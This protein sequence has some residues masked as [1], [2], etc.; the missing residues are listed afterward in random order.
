MTDPQW[1]RVAELAEFGRRGKKL[2]TVGSE[3]IALFA[4]GGE[5]FAFQ[6]ACVHKDRPLSRGTLLNGRVVCPGHQWA[7]DLRTG[8]AEDR[9]ECQPTYPVR[10]EDGQVW[11]LVRQPAASASASSASAAP[12]ALPAA[13]LVQE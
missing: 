6:D 12:S 13:D 5:V 7:F 4:H 11:V 9:A 3:R 1:A 2:V 8:Q 10:V